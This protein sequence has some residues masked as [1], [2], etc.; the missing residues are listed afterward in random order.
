MSGRPAIHP[1]D[2][3]SETGND[4]YGSSRGTASSK[5]ATA[6]HIKHLDTTSYGMAES[7]LE[8]RHF[9]ERYSNAL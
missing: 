4:I 2:I 5:N 8:E 7:D 1:E 6:R 9:T 3:Y